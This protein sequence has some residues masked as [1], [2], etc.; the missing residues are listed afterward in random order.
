MT[1]CG[2]KARLKKIQHEIKTKGS[3]YVIRKYKGSGVFSFIKDTLFKERDPTINPPKVRQF[4]DRFGLEPVLSLRAHRRPVH[5]SV[6]DLLNTLSFGTL[7]EAEKELGYDKLFHLTLIIN[8]KFFVEKTEVIQMGIIDNTFDA[9][10]SEVPLNNKFVTIKQMMDNTAKY[11]GNKYGPYNAINNNCQVFV[12]SILD[13]NGFGNDANRV[14]IKQN[15]EKLYDKMPSYLE[16]ITN[17]A[18]GTNARLNRLIQGEGIS[19]HSIRRKL[20]DNSEAIIETQK[21]PIIALKQQAQTIVKQNRRNNS[22]GNNQKGGF[23]PLLVS[24]ASS[25]L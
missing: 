16:K 23:F 3:D 19:N 14:F 20:I 9:E 11:M 10:T 24:L 15:I 17:V 1:C 7:R 4:L 21:D 12:Q 22:S 6:T 2:D 8:G 5:K 18:T 13:A 25:L